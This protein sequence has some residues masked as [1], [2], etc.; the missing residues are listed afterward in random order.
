MRK[1]L[2][3]ACLLLLSSLALADEG[4]LRPLTQDA[5]LALPK[6]GP[7]APVVIDVRT[8]EEFA[9]G[10]VPG[11][12]NIPHDQLAFRLAEVPKDRPV[13]LYCR[14]GRRAGIAAGLLAAN[15]HE[16][17]MHLQ[18][19]MPAWIERGRPVAKP[20]D[21]AA[22]IAALKSGKPAAAPCRGG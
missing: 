1:T 9:S 5:F 3:A 16:R 7:D 6:Q 8:A 17:L 18:G 14:S 2:H 13:V 4:G 20:A 15:G 12:M 19:D 10:Y 22:C 21:A 11:A